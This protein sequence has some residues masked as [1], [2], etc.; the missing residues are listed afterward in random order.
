MTPAVSKR[1]FVVWAAMS[2]LTL[3]A[4]AFLLVLADATTLAVQVEVEQRAEAL[5]IAGLI[6]RPAVNEL[7][8][9]KG[10]SFRL[11]TDDPHSPVGYL[12]FQRR[13]LPLT[14][15][16]LLHSRI[17]WV[18]TLLGAEA[19]L[20]LLVAISYHRKTRVL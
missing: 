17:L 16:G 4:L 2:F 14:Y 15:I 11:S 3:A 9:K 7:L 18:L 1:M 19:V 10:D 5:L 12:D 13:F 6:D 8:S 20:V